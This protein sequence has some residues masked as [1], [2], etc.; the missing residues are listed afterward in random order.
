[1]NVWDQIDRMKTQY[2]NDFKNAEAV[3]KECKFIALK[4]LPHGEWT[5]KSASRAD[6]KTELRAPSAAEL[7]KAMK[8]TVE[9]T[10]LKKKQ[11]KTA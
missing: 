6:H 4:A 8:A 1:M 3:A 5:A 10:E 2:E 11:G 9:A 7:M